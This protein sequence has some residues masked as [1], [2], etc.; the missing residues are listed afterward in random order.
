MTTHDRLNTPPHLTGR[1]Q[2]TYDAIFPGLFG[3]VAD[4]VSRTGGINGGEAMIAY[5]NDLVPVATGS[6]TQVRSWLDLL[7]AAG[8]ESRVVGDDRTAGLG[9]TTPG[10]VEL[11][12]HRADAGAAEATMAGAGGCR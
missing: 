6:L 8:I 5:A 10:S 9:A 1:H 4:A 11:W 2:H 7:G 3:R 12:A